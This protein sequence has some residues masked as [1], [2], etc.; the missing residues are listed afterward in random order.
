[1]VKK[2]IVVIVVKLVSVVY[3]ILVDMFRCFSI[4]ISVLIM[5]S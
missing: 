5:I 3:S 2:V 1:M 4:M